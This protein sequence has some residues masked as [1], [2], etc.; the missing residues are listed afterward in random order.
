[1]LYPDARFDPAQLQKAVRRAD[2]TPTWV[3]VWLR[4]TVSAGAQEPDTD[5][6]LWLV[7]PG[8]GQRFRL[9]ADEGGGK[10]ALESLAAAPDGSI[11]VHGEAVAGEPGSE[12]TVHIQGIDEAE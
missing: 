9:V 7:T 2:F 4:G 3:R 12:V 1:M 8:S 5:H 10:A 11:V 6:S